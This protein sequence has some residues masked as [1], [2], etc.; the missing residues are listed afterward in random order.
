MRSEV[1]YARS[2]D[3]HIAYQVVGDGP[4]DLVYSPGIWSNLE[5]MWEWPAWADY[6]DRLASFSRLI[7]FD[8]RGVGLS[9]RG[10]QA[11]ILELQTN[12]IGAVLD[13]AGAE[14]AAVFGGARAGAM[15]MLFAATHPERTRALILYAPVAKTVAAPDWPTGKSEQEQRRFV[16]RFTSEMGTGENLDLQGPSFDPSFKT[17]WAR[18]GR[19]VATPGAYEE[20]AQIFTPLDVRQVLPH[21]QAP[22]LVLHRA[23]DR[24]VNSAQGRA[25]AEAIHGARFVELP[26]E[27]HI[28]FLGNTDVLVDE[29]EEFL[30]GVRPAPKT[31]RILA[32][33]LFTDIVGSTERASAMGDKP[34]RDL[35]QRHHAAVR[36]ELQRFHGR[37]VDTAGDG[38]FATFDGPARG[39]RCAEA[40]RES[41]R[42]I[43]LEIRSGL[44]TGEV[45]IIG[46]KIS[47]IAVH[48]GA[49]IAARAEAGEILTSSTV[50]DL[51]A[52]SGLT[53]EDRGSHQLKGVPDEWRLFAVVS[54]TP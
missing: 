33:V 21:I 20:L 46:D 53:F 39:I 26:G 43:G 41:L 30:T 13:A 24:I 38:F 4:I 51:V 6:L 25:V 11:P 22:T 42:G 49:R 29:V 36:I 34:W 50:K 31:D 17:W 27:D 7:L 32:T 18:F 15:A 19:L 14:T 44:H 5:I 28:P 16:E 12:D 45:E 47:G 37:E 9:D 23:G 35:L 52:G 3:V 8:M 10:N 2:G 54:G 1:R 40:I 48:I